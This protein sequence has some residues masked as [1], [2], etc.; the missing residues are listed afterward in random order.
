MQQSGGVL[1][2]RL[3][4]DLRDVLRVFPFEFTVE[5]ELW[6]VVDEDRRHFALVDRRDVI[7]PRCKGQGAGGAW[8]HL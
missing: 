6:L 5:L 8:A 2:R 4:V 1:H 3:E 7:G